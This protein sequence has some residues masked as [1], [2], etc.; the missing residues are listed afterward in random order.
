MAGLCTH[1]AATLFAI[2]AVARVTDVTEE[3]AYWLPAPVKKGIPFSTTY[4]LASHVSSAKT[5]KKTTLIASSTFLPYNQ[6]I[7]S[8]FVVTNT[9]HFLV[10][11][12][13]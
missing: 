6:S 1:I 4:L 2:N 7:G 3:K 11:S 8:E 10:H 5:L 12:L 13:Q 9:L